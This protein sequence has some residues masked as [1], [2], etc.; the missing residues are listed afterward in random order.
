MTTPKA[1]AD[2]QLSEP[3]VVIGDCLEGTLTVNPHETIDADEVRCEID[4]IETARVLR[5]DFDPVAKRMVTR[6]VTETRTIFQA[7]PVCNP[8]TQLIN[9]VSRTFKLSV[10]I[11]VGSRPS[12]TSINDNIEWKIK[13]V[14]AVNDRPDLTTRTLQ[15][16]VI[17]ESQRPQNQVPKVRLVNCEY[18]QT[19]MPETVL[20]C[21]NCGARRKA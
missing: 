12:L 18:C 11:P 17:S 14:V 8:A 16:Q 13:G 21:P 20:A 6:Q 3:Y 7:N 4:C 9:G 2:L 10:N 5:T 19:A 1:D 15:L